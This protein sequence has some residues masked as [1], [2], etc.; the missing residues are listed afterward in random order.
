MKDGKIPN[1]PLQS[2]SPKF[3]LLYTPLN[4]LMEIKHCHTFHKRH[5]CIAAMVIGYS[6]NTLLNLNQTSF[7]FKQSNAI[8]N[9]LSL[10]RCQWRT[11]PVL[12]TV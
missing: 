3:I 5:N 4:F 11:S 10:E 2:S 8:T 12:I 6:R 9:D 1:L 7:M